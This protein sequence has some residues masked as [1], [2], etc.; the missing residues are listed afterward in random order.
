MLDD[1]QYMMRVDL[2]DLHHGIRIVRAGVRLITQL[3]KP[4][5]A[6][7]LLPST[8]NPPSK[9]LIFPFRSVTTTVLSFA[10]CAGLSVGVIV[11]SFQV[12]SH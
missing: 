5:S 9:C 11:L 2:L 12:P 3:M 4:V 6:M 7:Y 8:C 1:D 10:M